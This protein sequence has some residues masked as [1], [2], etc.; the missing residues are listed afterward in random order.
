ML[1][2]LACLGLWSTVA[3]AEESSIRSVIDK[4]WSVSTG[5]GVVLARSQADGAEPGALIGGQFSL[6]FRIIPELQV[7]LALAVGVDNQHGYAGFLIEPRY[8]FA[9]ER[10]W[11]PV[12]VG[13]MGYASTGGAFLRGGAGLERRFVSWAFSVDAHLTHAGGDEMVG[14][15]F[16]RFGVW[17]VGVDVSAHYHW[18]GGT[19]RRRFVP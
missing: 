6:H 13:G 5:Y 19:K 18:G 3:H 1:R 8:S 7:G 14:D 2:W 4:R 17:G 10:P 15:E 11:H 16:E 9:A 12:L